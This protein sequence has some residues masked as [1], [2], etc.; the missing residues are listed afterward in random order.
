MPGCTITS[1]SA[2]ADTSTPATPRRWEAGLVY[3]AD[4]AGREAGVREK[5][6]LSG[7]FASLEAVRAVHDRME[8]WS[9]LVLEALGGRFS[10]LTETHQAERHVPR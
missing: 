1:P 4:A 6:K 9:Q 5:H 8:T 7:S 3:V 2:S 10:P